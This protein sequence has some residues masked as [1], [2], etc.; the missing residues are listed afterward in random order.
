MSDDMWKTLVVAVQAL[1]VALIGAI[2]TIAVELIRNRGRE[3]AQPNS[4]GEI[5]M[6]NRQSFTR[7]R[8]FVWKPVA[9]AVLAVVLFGAWRASNVSTIKAPFCI[10][11][12]FY[13]S[14]WMGDGDK[15]SKHIEL[16]DQWRDDCHSIPCVRATYH[17][18]N[19]GWAGVYWQYPDGN[20][21]EKPGRKIENA[22]KV[23]F[24]ARGQNGGELVTFKVG[25]IHGKKNE[26]SFEKVVGPIALESVWK[27]YE[28]DLS[29]AD[30]SSTIG[31]FAWIATANGNPNGLTF[32]LD[33]ICF[34]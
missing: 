12:Y 26:D 6:S 20:W 27:Q 22:K 31:G 14:G 17:P 21:G 33:D 15:G 30:T 25:G 13:P 4:K 32:Y 7:K 10:D 34:K 29:D 18:G 11:N 5:E 24:W 28:I 3:Q 23:I 1:G 16:N 8:L 9:G 2:S 19:K